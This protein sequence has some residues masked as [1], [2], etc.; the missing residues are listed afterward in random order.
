MLTV[1]VWLGYVWGIF[2]ASV[3]ALLVGP[4]DESRWWVAGLLAAA[5][6]LLLAALLVLFW[7]RRWGRSRPLLFTVALAGLLAAAVSSA[8]FFVQTLDSQFPWF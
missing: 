8:I 3:I 1:G 6:Y 2:P 5:P 7:L 4:I